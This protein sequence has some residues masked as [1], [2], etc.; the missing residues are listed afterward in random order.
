MSAQ[1]AIRNFQPKN[2]VMSNEETVAWTLGYGDRTIS[3]FIDLLI[4]YNLDTV[5]D[6]RLFPAAGEKIHFRKDALRQVLNSN[7]IE[8]HLAGHQFGGPRSEVED[9]PNVALHKRMRG[10]AD[11]MSTLAFKSGI[12]KLVDL[13]Q[14]RR[15]VIVNEQKDFEQCHRKLLADYL[16]LVEGVKLIHIIGRETFH[17]HC[18]TFSAQYQFDTI[19]YDNYHEP[20]RQL[21]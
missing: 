6:I 14:N 8:F 1:S 17:E 16:Y 3:E 12:E 18:V 4:S 21:H 20:S 10:Y 15:L 11:Y 5:V 2:I 7:G 19:I 13:C 9:S